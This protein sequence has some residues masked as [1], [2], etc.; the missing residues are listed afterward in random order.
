MGAVVHPDVALLGSGR[1]IARCRVRRH[2][3][4]AA[5]EE[6][7]HH[8]DT[9]GCQHVD[10]LVGRSGSQNERDA[11]WSHESVL[12]KGDARSVAPPRCTRCT[13]CRT[14]AGAR[15]DAAVCSEAWQD[16]HEGD[17]LSR[18]EVARVDDELPDAH[19]G[20]TNLQLE[21]RARICYPHARCCRSQRWV[22]GSRAPCFSSLYFGSFSTSSIHCVANAGI[23]ARAARPALVG[24]SKAPR[25]SS[26][27]PG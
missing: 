10:L 1:P 6:G 18:G 27:G 4:A 24:F 11:P 17:D 25:S 12:R 22:S 7:K 23:L 9:S 26:R 20:P 8:Q 5:S 2:R 15:G 14:R 16:V 3:Q 21:P 13:G 19:L